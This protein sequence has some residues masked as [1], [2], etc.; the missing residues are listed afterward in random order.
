[1]GAHMGNVC[2]PDHVRA[3]RAANDLNNMVPSPSS[4]L[5]LVKPPSPEIV[6][7]I[8]GGTESDTNSSA[9]D[10]GDEWDKTEGVGVFS[11]CSTLMTKISPTWAEV[12]A[13]AQE[14]EMVRNQASTWEEIVST[15]LPGD[16]ENWDAED[17]QSAV[18]PQ[19][20]DAPIE[21]EEDEE[22][23]V[24]ESVTEEEE[25]E[26]PMVGEPLTQELG[27]IT[28]GTISQEEIPTHTGEV[29]TISIWLFLS[30]CL[31]MCNL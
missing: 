25:L 26:Q 13:A 2:H 31:P 20:E 6:K 14:E 17:S 5:E 1:M 22:Q 21:E 10:S 11:C 18:E 19:F 3:A 30:I 24:I 28:I 29:E 4:E 15:Q 12:H 7:G 23:V 16:A 8:P 27:E 9:I